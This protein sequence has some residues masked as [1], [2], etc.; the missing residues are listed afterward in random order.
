M[1]PLGSFTSLAPKSSRSFQPELASL[2]LPRYGGETRERA[3]PPAGRSGPGSSA[4]PAVLGVTP[5]GHPVLQPWLSMPCL[6][7]TRG[8]GGA[9]QLPV[10]TP[11]LVRLLGGPTGGGPTLAALGEPHVPLLRHL[12]MFFKIEVK[13]EPKLKFEIKFKFGPWY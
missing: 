5:G 8:A 6:S 2:S 1:S 3:W 13:F 7:G 10:L 11:C 12:V 9:A 4:L